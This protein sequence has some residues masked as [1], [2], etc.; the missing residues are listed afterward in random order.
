MQGYGSYERISTPDVERV[1]DADA[2][3]EVYADILTISGHVFYILSLVDSDLTLV[4][5]FKA[6]LWYE[7]SLL[8]ANSAAAI[9]SITGPASLATAIL[10]SHGHSDGD[11]VVVTGGTGTFTAING[12]YNVNVTNSGTFTYPFTGTFAGTC[13]TGTGQG[14]TSGAMDISASCYFDNSQLV[15]LRETGDVYRLQGTG[16]SD[17]GAPI[18]FRVRTRIYDAGSNVEKFM[19]ALDVVVDKVSS[20]GLV[21]YTDDDFST[22]TKFRRLDLS[23]RRARARRGGMF[24]RRAVE[25]RHT[26]SA[27][28]GIAALEAELEQGDE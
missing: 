25:F 2:F 13:T 3:T 12:T 27:K 5:D 7:W 19:G 9:T 24:S 26:L 14:W 23:L 28:V 17:N 18:D 4:Y 11:Q 21:R 16:V 20:T 22:Y 6:K 10:A 1:L 8:T 15:Q